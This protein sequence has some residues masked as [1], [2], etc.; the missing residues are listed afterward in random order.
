MRP[1]GGDRDPFITT[2]KRAHKLA[3]LLDQDCMGAGV[4]QPHLRQQQQKLAR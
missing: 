3:M 1:D 4:L 2:S